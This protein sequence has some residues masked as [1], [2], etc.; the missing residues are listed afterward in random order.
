M[1][2]INKVLV[3]NRG[4]IA[5]RIIRTVKEMGLDTAAVYEKPDS[6]AYFLRF[7]DQAILIGDGPRR[8]YLNIDK[9]IWAAQK[10]GA[11]AIHP[12]YGFLSEN[13]ELAAACEESDIVFIG[14]PPRVIRDLGNKVVAR[15][16]MKKADIP[17][18]PGTRTLS[19][20]EEGILEAVAFGRRH[21]YPIMFKAL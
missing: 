21:G 9:I 11:D 17:F 14:P 6:E 5:L 20:G 3:A 16:M 12:G 8:D 10:A 15:E 2:K 13:P 18:V 7:A 1:K 4:E 19:P